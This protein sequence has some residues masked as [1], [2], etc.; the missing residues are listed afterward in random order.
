MCFL[1]EMNQLLINGDRM[2]SYLVA[3][4]YWRARN[5]AMKRALALRMD[6]SWSLVHQLFHDT[7]S[8]G[9]DNRLER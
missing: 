8:G 1:K 9:C 6:A 4:G 5:S 7:L 2:G 3:D